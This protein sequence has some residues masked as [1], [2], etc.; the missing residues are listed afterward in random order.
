MEHEP[1]RS[2]ARKLLELEAVWFAALRSPRGFGWRPGF[3]TSYN[4]PHE[5]P[6]CKLLAIPLFQFLRWP[7]PRRCVEKLSCSRGT[8]ALANQRIR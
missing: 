2:T 7:C 1:A 3:A 6:S 4:S 8:K 5:S